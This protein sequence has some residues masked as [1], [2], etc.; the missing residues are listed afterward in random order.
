MSRTIEIVPSQKGNLHPRNKNNGRYDFRTL[1]DTFPELLPF[2]F[3]NK[4]KT[5]TINF[6]NPDAVKALNTVLL[7]HFYGIRYWEIPNNFLC[8]PVPGRADYIHYLADLLGSCNDSVIP[9]N[10]SV[11][12]LDIGT[13]ANCIYPI[14]GHTEYGWR[15]VGTEIDPIARTWAMNIISKN[16]F[17]EGSVIVREQ[18]NP[19]HIFTNIVFNNEYF[20]ITVCNPPFHATFSQAEAGTKRKWKNLGLPKSEKTVL[21]FGGQVNELTCRGGEEQFVSTMIH[22]SVSFGKQIYWFT[23]L[24]SK[25]STLQKIYTELTLVN[26]YDVRTIDMSQGQKKSRFVAWTFLDAESQLQWKQRRWNNSQKLSKK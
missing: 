25:R 7:K 2:V 13:G 6:A 24:L 10:D 23:T 4:H 11:T 18:N 20:D 17:P 5:V 8:P 1:I 19:E 26:P 16:D 12:V 22:E 15:F 9:K 14:L 21:N 3:T